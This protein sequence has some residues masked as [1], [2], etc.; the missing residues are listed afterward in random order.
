MVG[1]INKYSE[2]N[3]NKVDLKLKALFLMNRMI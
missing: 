3:L 2:I 1:K